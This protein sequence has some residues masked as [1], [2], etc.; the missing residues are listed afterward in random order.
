MKKNCNEVPEMASL[1][2]ESGRKSKSSK[3]LLTTVLL[4]S[5]EEE[6]WPKKYFIDQIFTKECARRERRLRYL[7]IP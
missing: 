5:A 6:E 3:I 2:S 7:L 4:E 1:Q